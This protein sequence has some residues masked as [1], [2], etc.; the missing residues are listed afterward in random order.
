VCSKCE[1]GQAPSDGQR[2]CSPCIAGTY[3]KS[4]NAHAMDAQREGLAIQRAKLLSVC[5]PCAAGKWSDTTG[6]PSSE[7]CVSCVGGS[8]TESEGASSSLLCVQPDPGQ[9]RSGISGRPCSVLNVTGRGLTAGWHRMALVQSQEI[10][11]GT[12]S[13]DVASDG[14]ATYNSKEQPFSPAGGYYSLRWCSGFA[15]SPCD[16]VGDFLFMVGTILIIGPTPASAAI[17][18]SPL[19]RCLVLA[20]SLQTA[21][22][23]ST[24]AVLE[25]PSSYSVQILCSRLKIKGGR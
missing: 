16:A 13:T 15:H 7:R 19:N 22:A 12:S 14:G 9:N 8:D 4:G 20:C 2:V 5:Q 10:V 1:D 25:R 24:V 17:I 6:A 21:F 11:S 3:A 23:S 18:A